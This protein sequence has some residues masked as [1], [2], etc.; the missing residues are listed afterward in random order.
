MLRL[1]KGQFGFVDPSP[2]RIDAT[3][4]LV[5]EAT[6]RDGQ[7]VWDL[8]AMTVDR[9]DPNAPPVKRPGNNVR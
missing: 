5:C 4:Q 9:R 7:A 8:N 2:A 6:L 3:Q 1:E